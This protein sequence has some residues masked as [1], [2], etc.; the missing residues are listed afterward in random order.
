MDLILNYMGADDDPAWASKLFEGL[1]HSG[2][3]VGS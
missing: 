2:I 3:E 1:A